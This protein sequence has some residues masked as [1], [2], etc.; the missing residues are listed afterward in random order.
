MDDNVLMTL[1]VAIASSSVVTTIFSKLFDFF[2]G[3][4]QTIAILLL[5]ALE[6]LCDKI[7]RQGYRTQM[8]TQR[9]TEMQKQYEKY[10]DGYA[11]SL[12]ADA[13]EK[14]LKRETD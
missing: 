1:I 14:P 5:S 13:M 3:K 11:K 9:L 2:T 10:G 7:A 4:R 12:V 8:Q 6:Q